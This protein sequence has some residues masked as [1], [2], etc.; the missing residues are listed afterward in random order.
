MRQRF[1]GAVTIVT[2]ATRGMGEAIVRALVA[3]GGRVVFTGRDRGAGAALEAQLAGAAEFVCQDVGV[4]EDWRAVVSHTLARMGCIDGLV[5]NAGLMGKNPIEGTT[6]QQIADLIATNQTSILL[7][8][9]YVVGPMRAGGGGS[10]VNIG[11][12]AALRG[13][14]GI[15]AYSGAKAAVAAMTRAAA[16]ELAPDRIRVNVVHPG[17]FA[18]RMLSDSMGSEGEEYAKAAVPMG[19][20][21]QPREMAGPVLFLLSD[22]SSYITGAELSVDGGLNL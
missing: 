14:A 4:E 11:S 12:V 3:E 9:K 8:M 17:P 18:T 19:R 6:P 7:G 10:I 20:V 21:G 15:S 16:I 1:E 5:N 2:G 13:M 22:E